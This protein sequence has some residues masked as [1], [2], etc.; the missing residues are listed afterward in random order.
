MLQSSARNEVCMH[1]KLISYNDLNRKEIE[2][3]KYGSSVTLRSFN[4]ENFF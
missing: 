3:N 4:Q 1:Y 2:T